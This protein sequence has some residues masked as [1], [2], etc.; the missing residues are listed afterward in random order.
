M[1]QLL[2]KAKKNLF[3]QCYWNNNPKLLIYDTLK[4]RIDTE[5]AA[6]TILNDADDESLCAMQP[7]CV[8]K[9]IRLVVDLEKLSNPKDITCDDMGSWQSN[10]T[11][12][13]YVVKGKSGVISTLSLKEAK[14]GKR[15]G[16]MYKLIK[17]YCYHKTANDLNKTIFSMTGNVIRMFAVDTIHKSFDK[18]CKNWGQ[19]FECVM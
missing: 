8:H 14:R 19:D 13:A 3:K 17:R 16:D 10:G 11:H 15:S 12:P 6:Q 4:D 1:I 18:Q 5:T 9:N 2:S 7:T